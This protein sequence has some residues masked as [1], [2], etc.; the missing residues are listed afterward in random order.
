MSVA[1]EKS[2]PVAYERNPIFLDQYDPKPIR[3]CFTNR[4]R[5][6]ERYRGE[7]FG[8]RFLNFYHNFPM[9]DMPMT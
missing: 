6:I 5:D 7:R 9:I 3:E 2:Q 4:L 8:W 1:S